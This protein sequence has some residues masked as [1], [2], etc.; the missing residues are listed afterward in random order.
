M[1]ACL[2]EH[3]IPLSEHRRRSTLPVFN[4]HWS[5]PHRPARCVNALF[6]NCHDCV[7]CLLLVLVSKFRIWCRLYCERCVFA[8]THLCRRKVHVALMTKYVW[9][10]DRVEQC[11]QQLRVSEVP[12]G[13]VSPLTPVPEA[14]A[15]PALWQNNNLPSSP[16]ADSSKTPVHRPG[17]SLSPHLIYH[18]SIFYA[19]CHSPLS[20]SLPVTLQAPS[21]LSIGLINVGIVPNGFLS[22]YL[23]IND[24]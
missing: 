8:C 14:T 5:S 9:Q 12:R 21:G 1:F 23:V 20:V 10:A 13:C 18:F 6:A 17:F 11:S 15:S 7:S 16:P 4:L 24:T 3:I 22:G 19:I 2:I